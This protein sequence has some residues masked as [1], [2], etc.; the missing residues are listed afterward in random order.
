[1]LCQSVSATG[2]QT[3][4]RSLNSTKLPIITISCPFGLTQNP[5]S[6]ATYTG[7][8]ILN[9][10][11]FPMFRCLYIHCYCSSFP[12]CLLL[13]VLCCIPWTL[14]YSRSNVYHWINFFIK[15]VP[16]V[17]IFIPV[18]EWIHM[19]INWLFT[20]D[21]K[22]QISSYVFIEAKTEWLECTSCI[23]HNL[24]RIRI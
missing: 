7:I 16:Y 2:I 19:C 17:S 14:Q 23:K 22:I 13:G 11:S 24:S 1:M 15:H 8:I 12:S 3:W 21:K 20:D 18:L 4:P 10:S 9:H 6:M 5:P